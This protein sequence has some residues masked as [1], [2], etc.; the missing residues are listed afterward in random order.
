MAKRNIHPKTLKSINEARI[1]MGMP[2]LG[3][4]KRDCLKCDKEFISMGIH[5]RL[6]DDCRKKNEGIDALPLNHANL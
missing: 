3:F 4:K 1:A 5:N 2:G 6:C